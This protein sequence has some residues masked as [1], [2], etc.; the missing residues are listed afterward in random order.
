M[1]VAEAARR[2]TVALKENVNDADVLQ[3][4]LDGKLR[5][6]VNFVNKTPAWPCKR[7]PRDEVTGAPAWGTDVTRGITLSSGESIVRDGTVTYLSGVYDLPMLDGARLAVE[8]QYQGLVDGPDVTDKAL[9][10]VFVEGR[11]REIFQLIES[12]GTSR[13]IK[14]ASYFPHGT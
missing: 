3:L 8:R 5:L 9:H 1:T 7:V 4:A 11:N 2:L 13:K 14:P 10:G 12:S 6:S